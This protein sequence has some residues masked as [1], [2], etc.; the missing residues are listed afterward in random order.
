MGS[1]GVSATQVTLE[2]CRSRGDAQWWQDLGFE[3][4]RALKEDPALCKVFAAVCRQGFATVERE[5][6]SEPPG[7][8]LIVAAVLAIVALAV[9]VRQNVDY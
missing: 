7:P 6:T 5:R 8:L 9:F 3:E 2:R 4:V 1:P